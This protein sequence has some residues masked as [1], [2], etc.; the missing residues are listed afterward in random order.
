MKERFGLHEKSVMSLTVQ[1]ELG[2]QLIYGLSPTVRHQLWDSRYTFSPL[3]K[4]QL[5]A[6]TADLRH[7]KETSMTG[8]VIKR[9]ILG[10]FEEYG[11]S[12][13]EV[14]EH[15]S[16][17]TDRGTNMLCAV[18]SFDSEVCIMHLFNNVVAHIIK[19]T[20][21]KDIVSN[22]TSLVRYI[23]TSHIAASMSCKLKTFPETRFNFAYDMLVSIKD[24][25]MEIFDVLK[26]KEQTSRNN[27]GLTDK[28]TSLPIEK[29]KEFG[30]Y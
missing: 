19:D 17:V 16:I 3:K 25:H 15:V 23:K 1:K 14:N 12:E 11:V 9:A 29:L 6:H 20:E 4:P 22:A 2:Q 24:N 18:S 28:L 8:I 21:L 10:I 13:S 30:R 7:I 26:I 27:R 5:E